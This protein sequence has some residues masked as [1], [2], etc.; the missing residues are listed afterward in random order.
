M[1]FS[2]S[3]DYPIQQYLRDVRVHQIIE[4]TNEVMRL[5][6]G[7]DLIKGDTHMNS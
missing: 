6:I 2:T 3:R 5:M 7:K 4:G 1:T